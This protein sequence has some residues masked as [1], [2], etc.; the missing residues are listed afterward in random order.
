M[1]Q[2]ISKYLG[3]DLVERCPSKFFTVPLTIPYRLYLQ[4]NIYISGYD[5]ILLFKF[6]RLKLTRSFSAA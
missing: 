1:Y 3:I 2:G 4:K 6:L 5:I